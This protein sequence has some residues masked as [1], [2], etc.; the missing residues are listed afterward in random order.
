MFRIPQALEQFFV[1]PQVCIG[2]EHITGKEKEAKDELEAADLLHDG[3]TP[4]WRSELTDGRLYILAGS[5][6]G[7]WIF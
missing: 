2:P 7:P 5:I 1:C 4:K 6:G 3:Q